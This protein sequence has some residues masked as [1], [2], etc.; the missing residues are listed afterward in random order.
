MAYKS[1]YKGIIFVEG[2]ED[3]VKNIGKVVYKKDSFYN[4]QLKNLDDVKEQLADKAKKAGGNAIINFKYGQKNTS[5]FK[6][7]LLALD[8]NVNWFGEG[9]IVLI[10]D[11]KYNEIIEKIK[12]S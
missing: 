2:Y 7:I 9:D 3:Y 10:D 5:W 1:L 11:D 12:N 8:D 6:S 4:N